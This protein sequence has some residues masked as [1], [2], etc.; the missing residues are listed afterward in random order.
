MRNAFRWFFVCITTVVTSFA[1]VGHVNADSVAV[2]FGNTTSP[3]L[4]NGPFTL[5][6][7]FSVNSAVGVTGLGVFDSDLDGLAESHDVGIFD[8]AGNL[9]VSATVASGTANSLI[10]QFRYASA[11]VLLTP[12]KNYE[13]GAV[14]G[15]DA[16]GFLYGDPLTTD[17]ATDPSINY[18]TGAYVFGGSLSAPWISFNEGNPVYFGPNFTFTS[19]PE[20]DPAGMGSVLA[21]VSGALGLLERRRLKS[22]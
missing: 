4:G 1:V 3:S 18:L 7:K 9:L 22:A 20:I 5:G 14:W 15:N 10:H 12:G 2:T 8:S 17:F 11:S 13:I 19:V 16:D 6:W 21:L